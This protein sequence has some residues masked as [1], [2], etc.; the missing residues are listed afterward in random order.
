MVDCSGRIVL[1]VSGTEWI[2]KNQDLWKRLLDVDMGQERLRIDYEAR[3][4]G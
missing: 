1:I 3:G 4:C 2:D